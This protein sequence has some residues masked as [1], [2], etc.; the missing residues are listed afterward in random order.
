M[1]TAILR[2]LT[3]GLSLFLSVPGFSQD[4]KDQP[5]DQ[6]GDHV[7]GYETVDEAYN[8]LEADE[9]AVATHHEGWVV[10]NQKLN[11]QYILWSFTPA[12]HPANPTVVKREIVS[13]D[14]RVYIRMTALCESEK[15]YCDEL[16]EDFKAINE[17]IKKNFGG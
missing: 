15:V 11:D 7:V 12:F 4:Q 2:A 13:R 16:I 9:S 3:A 17:R 8:A 1:K 10:Y 5:G 14:G 6:K